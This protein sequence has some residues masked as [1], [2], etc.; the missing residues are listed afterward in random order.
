MKQYLALSAILLAIGYP[1]VALAQVQ[2]AETLRPGDVLRITVWPD[3]GLS[4][5]FVV[6]EDGE[7]NL[8]FLGTV[9]TAGVPIRDL[10]AQLR[11]GY[12]ENTRNPVVTVTPLF[13]IGVTGSVRRPG[14]Y[15][16]PP[17]DGFFDVIAEAGGFDLRA[18]EN[19]VRV[20]R[21]GSIIQLNAE[22][23]IK[24]GDTLPLEALTLR[25]GDQIIVP[26][27]TEPWSRRDWLAV[28]NFLIS[29]ILLWDRL[30]N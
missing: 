25:S 17:T 29:L 4:G 19:D 2:Q 8:P 3:S 12:A 7:L 27:G 23:A 30:G 18:K 6:G 28:G 14:A 20:L 16:I 22:D 13:R 15:L 5:E 26:F 9:R 1:G 24:K 10:R 11:D 21:D